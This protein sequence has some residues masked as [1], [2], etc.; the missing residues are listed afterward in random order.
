[1]DDITLK[2]FWSLRDLANFWG[3]SYQNV[4]HAAWEGTIPGCRKTSAGHYE[5]HRETVVKEWKPAS[6]KGW[7]EGYSPGTQLVRRTAE[8]RMNT[9][10]IT[11]TQDNWVQVIKKAVSQAI[12]GD[13]RARQWLSNYLLGPPIQRLLAQVEVKEVAGFED[14]FRAAAIKTLLDEVRSRAESQIVD[15]TPEE[16]EDAPTGTT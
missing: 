11:V 6:M 16:V 7:L 15:V 5:I 10:S 12:S 8:E 13:Y 9:L 4:R 3:V 1:M 14:D 2:E